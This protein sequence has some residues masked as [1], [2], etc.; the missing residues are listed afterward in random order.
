MENGT[1]KKK[2]SLKK[3]LYKIDVF[4]INIVV[5]IA[6]FFVCAGELM[7]QHKY[8]ALSISMVIL[9]LLIVLDAIIIVLRRKR[10]KKIAEKLGIIDENGTVCTGLLGGFKLPTFIITENSR[11]C[12]NN[13]EFQKLCDDNELKTGSVAGGMFGKHLENNITPDNP[14]YDCVVRI[15]KR[16]YKLYAT[17]VSAKDTELKFQ[18][19]IC[20]YMID[21]S[22]V[23]RLKSLYRAKRIVVGE[24]IIDNYDEIFQASGEAV[25]NQVITQVSIVFDEWLKDKNAVIRRLM[26]E[27]YIFIC[28]SDTLEQIKQERFDILEKV[29]MI[30]V[31]N[32]IPATLSIGISTN[33][34]N[35]SEDAFR[36]LIGGETSSE[37]YVKAFEDTL[38]DHIA[39]SENLINLCLNRGGDQ[40][41]IQMSEKSHDSLFFGGSEIDQPREDMVKVRVMADLLKNEINAADNVMIMGH[42]FADLDAL[43][44]ALAVYRICT[45]LGKPAYIILEGANS[46]ID[47]AYDDIQASGKYASV[48]I[49]KSEAL[50]VIDDNTLLVIVDTFS[51]SQTEA[52]EVV[53]VATKK[54]VIDHHRQGVDAIK[55]TLF[56]YTE[57]LASST[58]ELL[59]E[60][61]RYIFPSEK[62]LEIIEAEMLYGGI[63][64]DTKNLYFKTGKRTFDVAAY[65]REI[66][67]V[68]LHVRKYVQPNYDDYLKINEIVGSMDVIQMT[69]RGQKVGI[70]FA[71]CE[72]SADEA[73]KLGSIATD[74]MLEFTGVECAFVLVKIG[75]N[76]SIKA[77]SPGE[78]N[79]QTIMEHPAIAGGGHL[80]AAAGF[81]KDT[82][83]KEVKSLILRIIKD[84]G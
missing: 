18:P 77:R 34:N 56:T 57:T 75:G 5:T 14:Y 41:V 40:A 65:L 73:N 15:G 76:V 1:G 42:K 31:G 21:I 26:R 25:A 19:M 50:N 16:F 12:W 39:T 28:E 58:S 53:S 35:I 8:V 69:Y 4:W 13:A 74:K 54:C 78:I 11:L 79:V 2:T 6:V 82:T 27:R 84:N 46:Q 29:K 60:M 44:S 37:V 67:V 68:P 20:C 7:F 81:V 61:I 48:F 45:K 32:T 43:G 51:E 80:T 10:M 23:E 3:L 59:I 36:A 66:G 49:S 72:M 9:V 63:L 52:P 83:V 38:K 71:E 22:D 47:V 55:D 64:V 30:S 33:E 62:V 70:A 17:Y 24:I